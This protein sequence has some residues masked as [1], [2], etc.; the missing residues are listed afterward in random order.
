[1]WLS[2]LER[3]APLFALYRDN[4]PSFINVL[5]HEVKVLTGK[6]LIVSLR[7]DLYEL[8]EPMPDKWAYRNVN[9]VQVIID[10]VQAEIEKFNL[11][12]YNYNSANIMVN[13]TEDR[14]MLIVTDDLGEDILV[15]KTSWL[16]L[17]SIGGYTRF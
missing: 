6:D 5:L 3:S 17:N 8:P 4:I 10:L 7:F 13:Q 12:T 16:Y 15:L 14:K 9:A 11:G 2:H 1:M